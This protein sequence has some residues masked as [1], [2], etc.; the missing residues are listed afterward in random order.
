M[1]TRTL[2]RSGFS[3]VALAAATAL[4]FG[5][6][7]TQ[8]TD[9][10]GEKTVTPSGLT[11]VKLAPSTGAQPGDTV[12]VRYTGKLT[13]GTKFDSSD[14]HPGKEPIS[15]RLGSGG[16]IKGWDEGITGMNIGEKRHLTIPPDLA[17][18]PKGRG[19]IPPNATLEFDV[20]LVGIQRQ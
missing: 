13:D 1:Q 18:G 8:P 7:S 5:Q 17:Y 15:F 16:V 2:L 19:T 10:S 12:R 9:G 20:E 6:A 11:I 14:D 3:L 4:V